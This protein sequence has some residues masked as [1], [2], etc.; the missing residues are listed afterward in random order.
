MG[1]RIAARDE[2]LS[3]HLWSRALLPMLLV[4]AGLAV[5]CGPSNLN[6]FLAEGE[7]P[8]AKACTKHLADQTKAVE[9][10][11]YNH[12]DLEVH[13]WTKTLPGGKY[14]ILR[15]DKFV[16]ALV[17][18]DASNV[19]V[20]ARGGVG[21]STLARAIESWSCQ[22]IPVFRVDLNADVAANLG[23]LKAGENAI[24]NQ[25]I[26]Q[27][28]L[29]SRV[30]DRE[31]FLELLGHHRFVVLLDSLDE[32]PYG[33]RKKVIAQID[34]LRTRYPKTAQSV[35]FAR[36]GIYS[37]DYGLTGLDGKL[38]I[39]ALNCSR[40]RSTLAWTAK[41]D[42][43]K[44]TAQSFVRMYHLDRQSKLRDRCYHP[45]MAT[46]RDIQVIHRMAEKFEPKTD[47][48]GLTANLS[49]VH[50]RIVA[51]R[52]RKEL[53]A[54]KWDQTKVLAAVDGMLKVKGRDGGQWNLEFTVKRCLT[55]LRMAGGKG[56]E[57]RYVCEKILQS[58][59][60]ERIAGVREWRFGHR[61]V[62]D[63]F[64][65][66]WLDR[67]VA[68][69]GCAAVD[70]N[71]AWLG[72]KEVVGYLVGQP[73]GGGCLFQVATAMCKAHGYERHDVDLL[74]RGLP[75]A[76][77]RAPLIKTARKAS[78]AAG[79]ATPELACAHKIINSL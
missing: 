45:Y 59:L 42:N 63:L 20:V 61:N 11:R 19:L 15:D 74:Y 13:R 32:V 21:K 8:Y 25:C 34:G 46:Y 60:F 72:S 67:E 10:L 40:V 29:T 5:G 54:L 69:G 37:D 4:G 58:A 1:N 56:A 39:P 16:D 22:R 7:L 65:A 53:A 79:K 6:A 35:I 57:N 78:K 66:R 30:S 14:A 31:T 50:E 41:D 3:N 76:A 43:A 33:K 77:A 24:I 75:R 68:K 36:P 38:E 28:K 12:V 55:S 48:G 62:S 71:A 2:S 23:R 64:L 44:A 18:G 17:R 49:Q 51:E 9:D 47:V 70:A 26:R 27:L 73:K 52:L